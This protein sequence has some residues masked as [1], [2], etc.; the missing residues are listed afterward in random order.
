MKRALY[1]LSALLLCCAFAVACGSKNKENPGKDPGQKDPVKPS[2][3]PTA[4]QLE[5]LSDFVALAIAGDDYCA[6]LESTD[7]RFTVSTFSGKSC[8]IDAKFPTVGES[9][10]TS[11]LKNFVVD[12]Q[13]FAEF[14]ISG[15]TLSLPSDIH[16]WYNPPLPKN[17]SSLNILFTGNAFCDDA[18]ILLPGMAAAA[19]TDK[20]CIARILKD[21]ATIADWKD[22]F[23]SS[24]WGSYSLWDVNVGEADWPIVIGANSNLKTALVAKAWDVVTIMEDATVAAGWSFN[25]AAE[26][27]FNALLDKI[28]STC[29]TKRPSVVMMLAPSLP[30]A[31]E[32]VQ[33]SFEG[34]GAKMFKAIVD[35]GKDVAAKTPVSEFVSICAAQQNLRTTGLIYTSKN[36]LTRDGARIDC[37]VGCFT[38][39]GAVFCKLIEPALGLKFA[40][41]T[42]RYELSSDEEGQIATAVSDGNIVY[43]RYAASNAAQYPLQLTD[44]SSLTPDI[45]GSEIPSVGQDIYNGTL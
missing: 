31:H 20:L 28:F 44:L 7:T 12:G 15:E 8:S 36:E 38:A 13:R 33:T 6:S 34:D 45:N 30:S 40:E 10:A 29:T 41:N 24:N 2:Y 19:E 11:G 23:E 32:I 37:G 26:A 21:G 35:Y 27:N 1:L 16:Q 43:C 17:C 3:E 4:A 25:A 42:Y 9:D 39:A 18:T 5:Q 22:G 14:H